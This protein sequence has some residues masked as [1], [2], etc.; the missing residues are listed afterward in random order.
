MSTTIRRT[1][2]ATHLHGL[3]DPEGDG[4]TFYL[5]ATERD[6]VAEKVI[7]SYLDGNEWFEEV[8]EVFAFMVTHRAIAVDV[9]QPVGKIDP[10]DGYDEAGEYWPNADC[11]CKC[12]YAMKPFSETTPS[13][14]N[15]VEDLNYD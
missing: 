11:E 15:L 8:T 10:D 3:Y 6:V 14:S 13:T 9:L 2:S 12:N 7:Q 4:L 5:N 1:P